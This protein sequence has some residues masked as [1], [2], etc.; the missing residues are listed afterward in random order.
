MAAPQFDPKE[1]EVKKELPASP[2]MPAIKIYNQPVSDKEAV[3]GLLRREPVWQVST[4]IECRLFTPRIIP[5]NVARS[6]VF[7]ANPFDPNKGGGPDMFGMIWEYVP[8]AG[9]SMI[10]PGKPFIEDFNEWPNKI[11]FPDIDSWD[12]AGCAKENASYINDEK[13]NIAWIMTGWYER[14]ITFMEFENAAVAMIDEDQQDAIKAFFDKATDLYI[15][16]MDKFCAYFP[17]IDAF[18]IHDDWGSQKETFFAPSVVS[19]MIVPHMKRATDFIH[20]KGKYCEL[21]SCGQLMK[22]IPN[23][24]AAGWD[25]WNGQAMNDT[26]KIYDLYGDKLILGVMPD[27]LDPATSTEEQQRQAARKY[28]D[29]FCNPKKPSFM[30]MNALNMLTPAF[31]EELYRQSRINYSK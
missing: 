1:M 19:E 21:H 17:G 18:C 9:G 15:K 10:R 25:I 23:I 27:P 3:R 28:A 16:I 7:E 30:N 8:V 11:K 22:Q 12:W 26:Q 29:R 20:S 24:I 6:F 2:F 31:R 4:M 13:F 5:D 14:L